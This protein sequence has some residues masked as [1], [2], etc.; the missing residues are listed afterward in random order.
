MQ[1][2]VHPSALAI[3][4]ANV[5]IPPAPPCTRYVSPGARCAIWY[6]VPWIVHAASGRAAASTRVT[7]SGHGQQ[8][9]LGHGYFLRVRAPAQQRAYLVTDLP[10][11]DLRAQPDDPARA[12][13]AGVGRRSRRRGVV[14]LPLQDVCPVEPGRRDLHEHLAR[15]G[16]RVGHFLQAQDLGS[17]RMGDDDRTHEVSP[18]CRSRGCAAAS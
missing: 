17:A 11:G 13:H 15:A 2:T 1:A 6:T 3:W 5:P 10:A 12:F 9:A 7:P 14:A 4:I 18:D 16:H 8:L